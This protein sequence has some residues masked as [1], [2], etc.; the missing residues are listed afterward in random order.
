MEKLQIVLPIQFHQGNNLWRVKF[1]VIG[2]V[3]AVIQLLICK[4]I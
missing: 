4:V 3:N 2:I 1:A